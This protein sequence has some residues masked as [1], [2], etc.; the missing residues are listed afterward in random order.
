MTKI[1]VVEDDSDIRLLMVDTLLDQG[2]E[3]TE[4]R[5]GGLGLEMAIAQRP[6]IVLL[7]VMMPVMDGLEVL[8]ELKKNLGDQCPVVIMVSAKGQEADV[9]D[10]LGKGAWGY[11]TKPWEA[12]DLESV[13]LS[14][15]KEAQARQPVYYR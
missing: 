12:G 5:H 10:A 2:W 15:E 1:L 14:A 6:D 13:I 8:E 3:V 9:A 11:V 4:A 7:D